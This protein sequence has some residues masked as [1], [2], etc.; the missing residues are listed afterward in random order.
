MTPAPAP[1]FLLG[2]LQM[3]SL[4]KFMPRLLP[5]VP[6][7]SLPMAQQELVRSAIAFCEETNAVCTDTDP[8]TIVA[9]KATYDTDIDFEQEV[10]RVMAAW[11]GDRPLS[12]LATG[13]HPDRAG[14]PSAICVSDMNTV[15]LVPTPDTATTDKLKLRIA[16][17]PKITARRLDDALLN[18]W[19][20]GVVFGAIA[21]LTAM[22]G[23]PFSD[24]G[25]AMYADSQFWRAVNRARIESRRGSTAATLRVRNHPLA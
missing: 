8:I 19:S 2:N 4:D 3:Q 7:C 11:F 10:T 12:P 18:K 13:N 5:W 17:R 24:A 6:G 25:Q 15:T 16:T 20:E 1:G 23:Q 21:R 9:G 22:P 14:S